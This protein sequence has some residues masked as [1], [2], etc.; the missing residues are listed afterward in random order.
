[1]L[2]LS[3]MF[4]YQKSDYPNIK[5]FPFNT[6]NKSPTTIDPYILK[7][8]ILIKIITFTDKTINNIITPLPFKLKHIKR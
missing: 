2:S 1:M 6:I 5:N 3:F 4:L 8:Q 7:F